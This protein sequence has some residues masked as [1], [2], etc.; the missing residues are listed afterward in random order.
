MI[1][2]NGLRRPDPKFSRAIEVEFDPDAKTAEVVWEYRETP[3]FYSFALGSAQKQDNG[4]VLIVD[5]TNGRLLEVTPDKRK[6]WELKV[7]TYYWIYKAVTVPREF[8][9]E[10]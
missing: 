6:V 1:M 4:N 9:T 10:W 2:D 7:E 3:D 8:F 5:G